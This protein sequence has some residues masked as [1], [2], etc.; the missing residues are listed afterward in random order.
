MILRLKQ[1]LYFIVG[2]SILFLAFILPGNYGW[3]QYIKIALGLPFILFFPG[4]TLIAA[5]FPGRQELDSIERIALSFGLSIAVV[6]FI[7]LALNFTSWGIH[8]IPI[9]ITLIIFINIMTSLA[10]YRRRKLPE[11]ERYIFTIKLELPIMNEISKR[12]KMILIILFL[13]L[14]IA[15]GNLYCVIALPKMNE[16]FTEF[17]ILGMGG[18]AEGYPI[19]LAAGEKGQVIVGVVNHEYATVKYIV[20]MKVGNIVQS[21]SQLIALVNEQKYEAPVMFSSDKAGQNQEVE[22]LL[23]RE[24]DTVP[25]RSLHLWVN[26][27]APMAGGVAKSPET[28]TAHVYKR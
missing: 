25:Y 8:Y 28:V 7:G 22:Y 21:T 14:F 13:V 17:Y 24:G 15:I 2:F 26:V 10:I 16:K 6:P 11:D 3:V 18:K 4:Y 27:H 5:L 23:F 1:D 19:D 9:V 20:Q 12:D